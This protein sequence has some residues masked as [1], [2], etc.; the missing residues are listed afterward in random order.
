MAQDWRTLGTIPKLNNVR[1]N[2]SKLLDEIV[3]ELTNRN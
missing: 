2:A 3:A 1:T